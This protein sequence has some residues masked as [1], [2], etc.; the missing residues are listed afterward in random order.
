MNVY[1]NIHIYTHTYSHLFVGKGSK[2]ILE[3]IPTFSE[4]KITFGGFKI[5]INNM[6][7]FYHFFYIGKDV[8]VLQKGK[9]MMSKNK[10]FSVLEG[11]HGEINMNNEDSGNNN[12]ITSKD[13]ILKQI[14]DMTRIPVDNIKL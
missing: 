13:N 11:A 8:S 6:N 7:K 14:S 12:E 3:A 10:I 4:N 5:Q 9:I 2:G 1:I